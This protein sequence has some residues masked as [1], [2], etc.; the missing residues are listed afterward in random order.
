MC[1]PPAGSKSFVLRVGVDESNT[2]R[3]FGNSFGSSTSTAHRRSIDDRPPS[4]GISYR[5]TTTQHRTTELTQ[6]TN[7]GINRAFLLASQTSSHA[8]SRISF[9]HEHQMSTTTTLALSK[10]HQQATTTPRQVGFRSVTGI[11][12]V[13]FGQFRSASQLTQHAEH[14]GQQRQET[15][16]R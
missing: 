10:C 7:R 16:T 15:V 11:A 12:D 5:T 14:L 3:S 4:L 2:R 6:I 8:V 1:R 13:R 9:Q